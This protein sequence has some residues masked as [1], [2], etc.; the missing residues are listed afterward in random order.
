MPVRANAVSPV[1]LF[2]M[3]AHCKVAARADHRLW[4]NSYKRRS[5]TKIHVGMNS[6]G[7]L[8]A[9][10]VMATNEQECTQVRQLY[11]ALQQATGGQAQA[12]QAW[13]CADAS[14]L[15][16]LHFVVFVM[17]MSPKVV[18]LLNLSASP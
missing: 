5:G 1:P 18:V 2:W 9:L 17:L 3:V 4:H 11:E 16:A 7:Q 14:V 13:L 12:G 10:T 6:L 8:I 15:A